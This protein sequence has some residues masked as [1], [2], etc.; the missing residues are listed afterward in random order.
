MDGDLQHELPALLDRT[1]WDEKDPARDKRVAWLL[2]ELDDVCSSLALRNLC[3]DITRERQGGRRA[4]PVPIDGVEAE[5]DEGM[6]QGP[7]QS[8]GIHE[9]E[10]RFA[11][12]GLLAMRKSE[13]DHPQDDVLLLL[14]VLAENPELEAG[15]SSQWPIKAIVNLLN[16]QY[17]TRS[18][19]QRHVDN[20]K[21][22]LE[23]WIAK[24]RRG[25]DDFADF[26]ALLTRVGR[27]LSEPQGVEQHRLAE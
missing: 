13:V 10:I 9:L 4:R 3:V 12:K 25:V 27:K 26:E 1:G 6:K 21:E 15:F 11:W 2:T 7:N 16:K 20:L 8:D 22:K 24:K 5:N 14:R 17:P 19:S 23:R 18:W